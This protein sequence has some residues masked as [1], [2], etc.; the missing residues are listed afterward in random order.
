MFNV[1]NQIIKIRVINFTEE[2]FNKLGY[3]VKNGDTICIPAKDLPNGSGTKIDVQCSYCGKIFKKLGENI[4]KLKIAFV[5]K[6]AKK[7]K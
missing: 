6:N 3:H 5:V 4:S 7:P 2:H 1:E